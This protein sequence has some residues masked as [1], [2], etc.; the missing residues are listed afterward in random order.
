MIS[1]KN[2]SINTKQNEKYAWLL[3]FIAP[4]FSFLYAVKNF[5]NPNL[6]VI[7]V[8]FGALFGLTFIPIPNS[9]STRYATTIENLIDYDF[10]KYIN[11]I[12]N[13]TSGDTIFPDIYAFTLFYISTS[14]TNNPQFFFMLA[15]LIY[16]WV[17]IKLVAC[18]YINDIR[19]FK[20]THSWFFL[21]I[22]FTL[23]FSAGING[24]RWPL[25]T[26]VFLYGAYN[27]LS[28]QKLKFLF[29]AA[30]SILIHFS[31]VPA[32]GALTLFYLVPPLRKSNLL[33]PIAIITFFA[34]TFF[35]G[36]IF[37]NTDL[38]G[39][40]FNEKLEGY[41]GEGY[42]ERRSNNESGWNLYVPVARFGNYF[43]AI[44]AVL[45]MWYQQKKMQTSKQ[46]NNLYTFAILMAIF[47][48]VAN[49]IV[50]LSTNRYITI[51]AFFVFAYLIEMNKLN[52]QSKILKALALVYAPIIILRIFLIVKTDWETVGLPL[53]THPIFQF[54]L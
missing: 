48:F 38:F 39:D 5:K 9:D 46:T 52:P 42:V 16:F 15:G 25:A 23:N 41:T 21:A 37:S 18:F 20:D 54:I 29:I 28:H 24:I 11:D 2:Y 33:F 44:F 4:L 6:R 7:I 34:G 12:Q 14:V 31:Y 27:L 50:D 43:F 47:S 40:V 1:I 13:I 49:A 17:L 53:L 32:I 8:L 26:I 36:L 10:S 30:T 19:F 51:M 45:L 3:F 22:V 35:S